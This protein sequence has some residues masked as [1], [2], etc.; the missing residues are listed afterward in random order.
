[1]TIFIPMW[2]VWTI[3]GVVGIPLVVVVLYLAALGAMLVWSL[4]GGIMR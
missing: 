2:L 3:A 4:R 1:M